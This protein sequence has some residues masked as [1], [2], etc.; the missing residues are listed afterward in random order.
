MPV[1]LFLGTALLT[2][3]NCECLFKRFNF[4]YLGSQINNSDISQWLKDLLHLTCKCIASSRLAEKDWK[5]ENQTLELW[6]FIFSNLSNHFV[7]NMQYIA[8]FPRCLW[9]AV[10]HTWSNGK[11]A[12]SVKLWLKIKT[13]NCQIAGFANQVRRS[14]E[15]LEQNNILTP[16]IWLPRGNRS[17]F[18]VLM[19]VTKEQMSG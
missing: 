19:R 16:L 4:L 9:T 11:P 17:W 12:D 15:L 3:V 18:S 10:Q 5:V 13:P 8:S 6:I 14:F 7:G 1:R 2:Y